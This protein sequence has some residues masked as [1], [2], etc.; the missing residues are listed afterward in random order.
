M[1]S[2]N[3]F[4]F[5]P[6]DAE[7]AQQRRVRS[8]GPMGVAVREAAD[9][10]QETTEAK[11]E[12]RRRNAEDAKEYRA[13]REEGRVLARLPVGNINTDDL[14]RDRLAL[15]AVAQSDEM[16]ELK[17]SIRERGQKEPIEVYLGPDGRY[18]LKKG[19][20]RLTALS[21]LYSETADVAFADVIARIEPGRADRINRYIEM[22]EENVI[23]EDLTF[24]EMA[25]VAITAAQDN[26]I[27]DGDPGGLVN[28]LYGALH[29]TKRSYIRGFVLLL[30]ELG[31]A[32][33]WPKDVARNLGV[34]VAR[35][36]KDPEAV[37]G[38][39]QALR[40]CPSPEA[41]NKTLSDFVLV[42]KTGTAALERKAE[43]KQKFEDRKSVV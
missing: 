28:R 27:E 43:P 12:Q 19:W 21:Q 2:K 15:E 33:A 1:S 42:Q 26:G 5:A 24:A 6:I 37:E 18:Q 38:L 16:E 30:T 14:P 7:Q 4:G 39:R 23:R 9:N 32:L 10:L 20:R 13:A 31:D 41:Q 8:P 29:K 17:A 35:C 25:Q 40:N 22:V 36:L 34:D 11:V 3:R